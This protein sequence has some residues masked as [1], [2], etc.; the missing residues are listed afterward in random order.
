MFKNPSKYRNTV[1]TPEKKQDYI[2]FD[3][4]GPFIQTQ[5]HTPIASSL[6][7]VAFRSGRGTSVSLIPLYTKG[8]YNEPIVIQCTSLV[9][10]LDCSYWGSDYAHLVVGT[11]QMVSVYKIY[12][13]DLLKFE[14]VDQVTAKSNA[15]NWSFHHP[16]IDGICV[17]GDDS[18]I[19]YYDYKHS[20]PLFSMK[21]G[22]FVSRLA[23]II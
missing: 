11:L 16:S 13:D 10:A 20:K 18:S 12:H 23:W 19:E 22:I 5:E 9:T 8:K 1:L 14:I 2:S 4:N 7:W 21:P 6:T 17:F 3:I 15:V